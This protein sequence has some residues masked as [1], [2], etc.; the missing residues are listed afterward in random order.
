[1]DP[2]EAYSAQR[3]RDD[4]LRIH[5]EITARGG[6]PLLVGGAGMYLTAVAEGFMA[7]PGHSAARLAEVRA[8]LADC[9]DRAIRRRLAA[10]D[11]KAHDR[12]HPRDRRRSQRALE[13]FLVSGRTVTELQE[14]QR[15]D[16]A[17]GLGFPT[18]VLE[19]TVGEL[20]ERIAARTEAMLAAGWIEETRELLAR[21]RA[22]GPGLASI[23]YREIVRHLQGGLARTELAPVV[24]R[25]TRQYAKRQRTWFR[26]VE[27]SW[28]GRP[29]DPVLPGLVLAELGAS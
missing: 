24:V 28:R 6:L 13:I 8:E 10:A 27:A 20:D 21:H 4:F 7:I 11:R 2:D 26:H 29:D 22:D 5:G 12:I 14:M 17:A 23:G 25:A 19:R 9:D 3:F 18:F 1:M 16:P 15:V